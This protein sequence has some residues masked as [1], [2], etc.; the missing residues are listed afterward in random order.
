MGQKVN[1]QIFRT[2]LIFNWQSRWFA[3]KKNY[4]FFVLEDFRIRSFIKKQFRFFYIYKTFIERAGNKLR[5]KIY[6]SKPGIIVGRGGKDLEYLKNDIKKL[7]PKSNV[8]VDVHEVKNPSINA[9]LIAL[10]VA[11]QL[12]KKSPF[13][14]V[15]KQSIF[16]TSLQPE[17][18]GVRIQISGRLG[19]AEIARKE[20][21]K[22]GRIP[23]QTIK[24]CVNYGFEEARTTYGL[25][26]VKC[27][28]CTK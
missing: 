21:S 27:W 15:L 9:Q 22:E 28:V 26:G 20:W 1:P 25:I 24:A 19:G 14:R 16:N 17:V 10:N 13:R 5:V 6:T 8:L 23:L 12:E 7:A 4:S 18:A 2:P 3:N 11:L